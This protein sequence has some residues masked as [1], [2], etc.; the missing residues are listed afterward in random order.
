MCSVCVTAGKHGLANLLGNLSQENF[1][2]WR[3][4]TL[5]NC[6]NSYVPVHQL[7]AQHFDV[8]PFKKSRDQK[9]LSNVVYVLNTEVWF[10]QLLFV[11]W[12]TKW[13][14]AILKWGG[15]CTC[16]AAQFQAGE[17]V[18]CGKKGRL[19]AVAYEHA[20]LELRKGRDIA[21]AWDC[22]SFA[23]C[24]RTFLLE[25]IGCV[26]YTVS[27]AMVK[28]RCFDTIP[29]ACS[30]LLQPG[31]RD[32][33]LAQWEESPKNDSSCRRFFEP[34]LLQDVLALGADGSGASPALLKEIGFLMHISIDDTVAESPH[35]IAN[36]ITRR[37]HHGSWVWCASTMRLGQ[38]LKDLPDMLG[39]TDSDLTQVWNNWKNL[40]K[41]A[42]RNQ[43]VPKKIS[44][45]MFLREVS[46]IAMVPLGCNAGP[47][48]SNPICIHCLKSDRVLCQCNH[49]K[50]NIWRAC[51]NQVGVLFIFGAFLR[52]RVPVWSF[53]F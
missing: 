17:A 27:V 43:Q 51:S 53:V 32:R 40:T 33:L 34:P 30:R 44:K 39:A 21:I 10:T 5:E 18:E 16:H 22:N 23:G 49:S 35:A 19:V 6:S 20:Q 3:W 1:A 8:T 41:P 31:M 37:A 48:K 45:K 4:C 47:V 46:E 36:S 15:S 13:I 14:G 2:S 38:N 26:R 7:L 50:T 28:L 29:L 52:S 42:G 11:A 24:D 9:Q 25:A 12:Y